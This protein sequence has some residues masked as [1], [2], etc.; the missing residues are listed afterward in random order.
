[1][2]FVERFK[3]KNSKLAAGSVRTYLANIKR[4][5]KMAG[6]KTAF[7]ETGTWL[8]KK[9]LLAAV[10]K[11]PLNA[12][13]IISAAAVKASQVYGHKV[14]AFI[15]LMTS[16]SK[17]FEKK[18]DARQKT[19]REKAL[20]QD[21][22]KV[23]EAGQRLWDA[24]KKNPKDWSLKDLRQAQFAYLLLLYGK[25][26]PRGLESLKLPGKEGPNQLRRVKG[27]FEIILRDYKTAKSRGP[28]KF[29]LDK[30][31][32]VPT[33]AFVEGA[34]RLNKH[35]FV[36]CNAKGEKNSKPSFTKLLTAATRRGGLKGVS[37]QLL[38]VY[39]STENREIIEKAQQLEA[40]M[41]HGSKESKRY[42]KKG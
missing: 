34:L 23:F 10:R 42:A 1:M 14:P 25:H 18:R 28:S 26:T 12:R 39:K 22:G 36:F 32:N 41:G 11:L 2:T 29:R 21:Y 8:S 27:G 3:K 19:D 17:N 35:G 20:W 30:Q 40:E 33:R 7:P 6:T 4:L 5:A 16:A 37:V 38:R 13:K 15:K 31:L 24:V 9:G